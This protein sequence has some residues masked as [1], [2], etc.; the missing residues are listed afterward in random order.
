VPNVTA[1]IRQLLIERFRGV[2]ALSWKPASGV[3]VILGGGD[4]GK[5]TLLDAIS[6]LFSP[7]NSSNLP[8]TDYR[9][10]DIAAGFS[11][12]AVVTLRPETGISEQIKLS[13]PWHWDGTNVSVPDAEGV[14]ST[15]EQEVYRVRVRGTEDLELSYEILQPDGAIDNFPVALRRSIGLVKLSG[16]DRNDRDLRL[17]QGSA[18]DRLLSDR[19][20][21][22]R[23][24]SELTKRDVKGELVPEAIEALEKLNRVFANKSLPS[25]LDL[26]ITGGAGPSIAS[27]VGLTADCQGTRLPVA[28]WG[29]GTR[30][31]S[32]L[33]IA[34]QKQGETPITVV[35]EIERGLE[36]Y[37]QRLLMDNLQSGTSQVFVTTHSPAVIAAASNAT[38]WYIDHA[39]HIGVLGSSHVERQRQKDPEMFLSRLAIVGEGITEVSFAV[40]ILERAL[41]GHLNLHGVHVT[42]AQGHESALGL[43]EAL[44][45]AGLNFGGFVDNEERH[46]ERWA[47]LNE[48]LGSLLFQWTAGNTDKNVIAAVPDDKLEALIVDPSDE[49]TGAR[50]RTLADRLDI[51]DKDF[52]SL[53]KK[54]GSALKGTIIEAALG[55]VPPGKEEEKKVYKSDAGTW[56]KSADG[57]RE[58][59]GKVFSLGLWPTFKPL[60]LPF[61]NSVRHAIDLPPLEDLQP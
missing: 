58:L 57:G 23:M 36:P 55:K 26:A 7:V 40:A 60:L 19:A 10:R 46:P 30:R 25:S 49:K 1:T 15:A 47:R 38:L 54:A 16:E 28:S 6:L 20:L 35:D 43:L 12:E 14:A 51:Q 22:S 42:D 52:L 5:T 11:I 2:E 4:V 27:F 53:Y 18:L 45:P 9:A 24:A 50:L 29:A 59:A 41:R 33:A 61:C 37:R 32:A 56:F 39:G 44:I 17:V 31:L 8:D 48:R 13:W 3:N 21:R 34:E